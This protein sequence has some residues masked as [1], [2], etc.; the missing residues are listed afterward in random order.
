MFRHLARWPP[1]RPAIQTRAYGRTLLRNRLG[2]EDL[3][4][5]D[6]VFDPQAAAQ[7]IKV[8]RHAACQSVPRVSDA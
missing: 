5:L 4:H 7:P 8:G 6:L 1:A 3:H 2:V